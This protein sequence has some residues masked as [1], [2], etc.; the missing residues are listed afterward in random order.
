MWRY[1][2]SH[3]IPTLDRQ[4]DRQTEL[5]K[6]YRVLHAQACWRAIKIDENE[7]KIWHCWRICR[8]ERAYNERNWPL[9]KLKITNKT[10]RVATSRLLPSLRQTGNVQMLFY[11]LLDLTMAV[12]FPLLVLHCQT[13]LLPFLWD[14]NPVAVVACTLWMRLRRKPMRSA[15]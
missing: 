15:V 3:T 7:T 14:F 8:M 6:Q 10:S 13:S 9:I 12:S 11:S 2:H 1:V 5:I 4:T